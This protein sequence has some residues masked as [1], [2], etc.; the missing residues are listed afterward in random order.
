MNRVLLAGVGLVF[1]FTTSAMAQEA[2]VRPTP[3]TVIDGKTATTEQIATMRKAVSEFIAASDT[4]QNCVLDGLDAQR[5]AA[6]L[7]KTKL[8][9]SVVK[10]GTAQ[11]DA[12]QADKERVG[13]AYN[14]AVKAF[15]AAN[16]S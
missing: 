6:K 3:P 7:A 11:V 1:G 8:P 12:N 13:G 4:F 10:E 14:A 16:P 9:S 15:R 2:C 5:K